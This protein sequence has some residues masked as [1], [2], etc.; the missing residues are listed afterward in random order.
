[1]INPGGFPEMTLYITSDV[2]TTYTVEI[3]GGAVLQT[4]SIS[5]GQVVTA[6]IPAAYFIN[7]EGIFTNK[8]IRVTA[9]RP[10]VVYSYITRSQA[11]GATLCLPT[12]VLGKEY[13]SMN[14][15]QVSNE[16]NSCSYFTVIAVEDNTTIEITP[17][18]K[19][20]NGWLANTLHT[21]NL[22]KGEIYQVLGAL[23]GPNATTGVD[24]TGS[25]VQSISSGVGSC[26]KIAVFSGS[27]KV[28]IPE[29]CNIIS[30]DNLYEQLYPVVSWGKR[31]LTAPSYN[32]PNNYYRIAKSNPA[33]NVYVNGVLVPAGSFR[34]GVWY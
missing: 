16:A 2:A 14:F 4:G 23:D 8:A 9:A 30:S 32:N 28:R 11:S 6:T 10:I 18:A 29:S 31:Y 17:S 26:K 1:M 20:K 12:P 24:L 19:T 13:Y 7:D 25:H 34:N 22:N 5:A 33:A 3:Y 27:G 15:T 21:I